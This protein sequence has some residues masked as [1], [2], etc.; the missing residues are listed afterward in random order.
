[1]GPFGWCWKSC[2]AVNGFASAKHELDHNSRWI[3]LNMSK[4]LVIGLDGATLDLVEPW[5]AAGKLPVLARMM[6]EGCYSR[7]E[8]VHPTLSS[9]A[10]GSFMTGTNPGKHGLIDFVRRDPG[11]YRLRTLR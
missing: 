9:A 6:R 5:A 8:S 3:R 1:M 2:W 10:W 7:L 11:S 4:V